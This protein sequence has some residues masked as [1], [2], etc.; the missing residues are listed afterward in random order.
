MD[1]GLE[2]AGMECRWQVEIN[3]YCLR[4]LAKHWPNV[5]RYG[6]IKQI[7][8]T[9]LERVDLIAGGFPCQ[10]VS[11]AGQRAGIDGKRSGLW[12]E[13]IRIVRILRPG[14]VLV[15]NVPGLLARGM[16]RVLGDLAASGYDAQWDCIPAEAAGAP[17][18]RY[19]VFIVAHTECSEW[20]SR[21]PAECDLE[22]EGGV[23]GRRQ[24]GPSGPGISSSQMA[25]SNGCNEY[26]RSGDV[27][28]GRRWF[29]GKVEADSLT[30]RD[31]WRAEPDLGRVAY[32]VPAR[33]DRLRGLGNAV[34][35]QVAE[36]IGRRILNHANKAQ[37]ITG[38]Y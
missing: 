26:G 20:R 11:V 4:V 2:R 23:Q 25:N 18:L 30:G 6:D 14:F 16:G 36:W 27:Q 33:L 8:G 12:A 17:H 31:E 7:A 19:R 21:G 35:P 9:E 37:R 5:K 24:E 3:P 15:E 29:S 1:L 22:R 38:Q 13:Y 32:G 34:V 10:D 28:M